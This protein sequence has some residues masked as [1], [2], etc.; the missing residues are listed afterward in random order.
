MMYMYTTKRNLNMFMCLHYK[1]YNIN[2]DIYYK[3]RHAI[4]IIQKHLHKC[5]WYLCTFMLTYILNPS[6]CR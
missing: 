4:H 2:I 6:V 1:I 5:N 3:Y